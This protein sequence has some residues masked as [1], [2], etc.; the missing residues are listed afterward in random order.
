MLFVL[1]YRDIAGIIALVVE[2]SK[3]EWGYESFPICVDWLSDSVH[4]YKRPEMLR[5]DDVGKHSRR[6]KSS[7]VISNGGRDCSVFHFVLG[8]S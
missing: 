4:M 3:D 5:N 1:Q 8:E 7:L 2:V 6:R